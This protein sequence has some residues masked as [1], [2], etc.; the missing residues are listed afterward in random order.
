MARV[1]ELVPF[2]KRWEGGYV[3]D[4]DDLGGATNMGVTIGTYTDYRKKKGMKKPT[5]AELKN[6]S[7]EEWMDI[8]K[9]M[10]WDRFKADEIQSQS[11]ANLC[12]DWIW[13]SGT[14][15]IK[16]VQKVV[17][18]KQDGIVGPKTLSAIN[19]I[20]PLPLFGMIKSERKRFLEEICRKRPANKKFLRGWMNRLNDLQFDD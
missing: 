15:A 11:V 7:D 9:T 1:N 16:R 2:I 6:I 10:Y 19:S 3:C 12:V 4:P 17:G 20:S 8:L 14:T 18:A 13:C 5:V